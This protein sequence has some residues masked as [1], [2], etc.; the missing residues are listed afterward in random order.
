MGPF[1]CIAT[2]LT[3]P[4]RLLHSGYVHRMPI[5]APR[6]HPFCWSRKAW[7]MSWRLWTAFLFERLPVMRLWWHFPV[8][9]RCA[10]LLIT[11]GMRRHLRAIQ[12]PGW[13]PVMRLWWGFPI[14]LWRVLRW[15]S[16]CLH[17]HLRIVDLLWCLPAGGLLTSHRRLLARYRPWLLMEVWLRWH[18]VASWL[19]LHCRSLL[20]S[21]HLLTHRLWGLVAG[22]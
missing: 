5:W 16:S 2:L 12:L 20:L 7:R 9:V 18:V 4:V 1:C 11:N 3:S 14:R 17:W 13:L 6:W 8:Q 21:W 15:R 19:L 10:L 22:A